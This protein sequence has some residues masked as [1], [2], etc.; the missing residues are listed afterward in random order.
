MLP[1]ERVLAALSRQVPDRVPK[2]IDFNTQFR[3]H[4]RSLDP[5]ERFGLEVRRVE[6]GSTREQEGFESYLESLPQHRK[7]RSAA[8]SVS[9]IKPIIVLRGGRSRAGARASASHTGALAGSS[10]VWGAAIK[11]TGIVRTDSMEQVMDL[12]LAFYYAPLPGGRSI[13]K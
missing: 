1:R 10:Q 7:F 3:L 11:Q 2:R 9:R 5:A 8:R 4:F 13:I 6:S 12:L